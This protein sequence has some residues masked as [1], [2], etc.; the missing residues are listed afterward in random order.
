MQCTTP[1]DTLATVAH[2]SQRR[3]ESSIGTHLSDSA[4]L[5]VRPAGDLLSDAELP[6][7]YC[8]TVGAGAACSFPGNGCLTRTFIPGAISSRTT[9]VTP[10]LCN[11]MPRRLV[12]RTAKVRHKKVPNIR[13]PLLRIT[14]GTCRTRRRLKYKYQGGAPSFT[15][16]VSRSALAL[17]GPLSP[18]SLPISTRRALRIL[19]PPMPTS[20]QSAVTFA[21]RPLAVHTVRPS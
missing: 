14:L 1:A 8:V 18:F 4:M 3:S 16:S 15:V 5:S 17:C 10:N 9:R 6:E 12:R 21:Q 13:S 2:G 20:R 19:P 11:V 7:R